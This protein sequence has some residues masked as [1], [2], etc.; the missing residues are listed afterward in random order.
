MKSFIIFSIHM[1]FSV[2]L[3]I[4]TILPFLIVFYA[5]NIQIVNPPGAFFG[6]TRN[7]YQPILFVCCKFIVT[8]LL[9]KVKLV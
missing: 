5:Y 1:A 9:S 8:R 3:S 2:D 6:G 4:C 7:L